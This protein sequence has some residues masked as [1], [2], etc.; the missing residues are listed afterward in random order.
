MTEEDLLEKYLE[1]KYKK[2]EKVT[3][4]DCSFNTLCHINSVHNS[5]K[6]GY[7]THLV[8]YNVSF[9][10]SKNED[11]W[12]IH[13]INYDSKHDRWIDNTI[14]EIARYTKYFHIR[15]IEEDEYGNISNI[16]TIYDEKLSDLKEKIHW[17]AVNEGGL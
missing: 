14:G 11:E 8:L 16:L 4:G 13:F 9:D 12:V 2:L 10:G 17:D 3:G 15:K 1:D 7:E 5:L 6:H